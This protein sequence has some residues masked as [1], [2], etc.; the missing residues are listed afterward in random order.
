M[1]TKTTEQLGELLG[2]GTKG[3]GN[4]WTNAEIKVAVGMKIAGATSKM[5]S[6]AFG[7]DD[8]GKPVHSPASVVYL[9]TRRVAT[10][11]EKNGGGTEGLY[12]GLGVADKAELE[13]AAADFLEQAVNK[14]G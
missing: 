8:N 3:R 13:Q 5:I 7:T 4:P 11:A 2:T 10:I 1:T 6:E 12:A 9:L 14:A